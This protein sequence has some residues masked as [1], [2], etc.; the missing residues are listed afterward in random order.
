[1]NSDLTLGA[2]V[3]LNITH[4]WCGGYDNPTDCDGIVDN[5]SWDGWIG[6]EWENGYHNSYRPEDSDLIPVD[7]TV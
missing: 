1:M 7:T 3:R 4:C 6:V 5:I 2:I